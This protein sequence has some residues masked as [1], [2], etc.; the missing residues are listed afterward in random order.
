MDWSQIRSVDLFVLLSSFLNIGETVKHVGLYV[1]DFGREHME[2]E[3][4]LSVPHKGELREKEVS[5]FHHY[6]AIAT[7]SSPSD[8]SENYSKLDKS[9]FDHSLN[10]KIDLRYIF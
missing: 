3:E 7:F 2:T 5:E 1:S 4:R 8:A 6:F 9:E 10:S